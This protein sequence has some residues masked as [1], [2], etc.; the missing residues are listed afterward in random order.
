MRYFN[1]SK[2]DESDSFWYF[3]PEMINQWDEE[4][5][6]NISYPSGRFFIEQLEYDSGGNFK[7]GSKQNARLKVNNQCS[8]IRD[9][10]V[11][12][13]TKHIRGYNEA[14]ECCWHIEHYK[15]SEDEYNALLAANAN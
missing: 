12:S 15:L 3:K 6:Q 1:F 14:S 10:T 5:N 2:I 9:S 13:T 7:G 11:I 8:Q 4:N